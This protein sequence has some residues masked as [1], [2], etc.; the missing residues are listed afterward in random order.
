V[1]PAMAGIEP[2]LR[3]NTELMQQLQET[4]VGGT[5]RTRYAQA[6]DGTHLA[7]QVFGDGKVPLVVAQGQA[8]HLEQQWDFPGQTQFLRRV[9]QLARVVV[10]DQRGCGVS[11]RNLG[12]E[13]DWIGQ[14]VSDLVAVMD[15]AGVERAALYGELHSGPTCIRASV[16]HPD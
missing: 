5:P 8:S 3:G 6:P 11:D 9:G 4:G 15:A 14:S 1:A 7:Y 13:D 10:Y 12:R 16:E 2:R